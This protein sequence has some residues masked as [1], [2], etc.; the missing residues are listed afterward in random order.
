MNTIYRR[1]NL[2]KA[3]FGTGVRNSIS[4]LFILAAIY[5]KDPFISG[6]FTKYIFKCQS[7]GGNCV[8]KV[9]LHKREESSS[10]PHSKAR[11]GCV[12]L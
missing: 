1:V 12:C 10:D 5:K 9:L 11:H 6:A 3:Q 8:S 7:S 4:L 2:I